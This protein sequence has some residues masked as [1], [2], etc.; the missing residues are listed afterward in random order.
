M[1]DYQLGNKEIN[2]PNFIKTIAYVTLMQI[3]Y[4]EVKSLKFN[5]SN[6]KGIFTY[7]R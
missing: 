7:T 1:V 3:A 4:D 6:N 5:F 2:K